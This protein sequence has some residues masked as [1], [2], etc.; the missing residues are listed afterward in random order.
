[1]DSK[2]KSRV[3]AAG[4][5]A[6]LLPIGALLAFA[7][8]ADA[9]F[10]GKN[11]KIAFTTVRDN[12]EEISTMNGD[13]TGASDV[14]NDPAADRTP[15]WSPDGRRLAFASTRDVRAPQGESEIYTMNGDGSSVSKLTFTGFGQNDSPSW[16]PDGQKIVFNFDYLPSGI[17]IMNADGSGRTALPQV[18]GY[19]PVW[20]PDGTKIAF[21]RDVD[22]PGGESQ[23]QEVWTMNADFSGQTRLVGSPSFSALAADWSPDGT[24]IAF[25]GSVP[26][27]NGPEIYSIGRDG[28]GQT[29]LTTS[30]PAADGSPAWSPDGTKIAFVRQVCCST[31]IYVMNADGNGQTRLTNN[32]ANERDLTWQPL[33]G[34]NRS[35]FKNA[36]QFCRADAEFLGESAFAQKYG[37]NGNGSN[38]FGKCVSASSS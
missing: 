32:T 38:A 20:S 18:N 24:K 36:A 12:N 4:L 23:H 17:E 7:A 28:S 2:H 14:T 11:G 15:A 35:D 5:A 30:P 21:T 34:P 26:G 33:P 22:D 6:L 13:G 1:V 16:S 3:R 31:E 10:P 25:E 19:D 29:N 9:A 37:T 27:P 8:S